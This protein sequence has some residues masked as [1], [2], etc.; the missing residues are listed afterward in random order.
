MEDLSFKVGMDIDKA[1]KSIK[2]LEKELAGTIPAMDKTAKELVSIA[3]GG[4]GMGK[5]LKKVTISSDNYTKALEKMLI[6]TRRL[7]TDLNRTSREVDLLSKTLKGLNVYILGRMFA[8]AL[9]GA[10]DIIE[11]INMFNISM[12][13]YAVEVGNYIERISDLAG[14]D[15]T[16][17]LEASANYTTL[18]RAM[19]MTNKN[20]VILGTS[21]TNLAVDMSSLMNIPISQ[22][23]ADFR[24]GLVGQTEVLT[25]YG[26]DTTEAAIRSEVLAQGI[27]KSYDKM[28][29]GEKMVFRYTLMVKRAGLAHLDFSK[30]IETPANQL[31]ILQQQVVAL[32]RTIGTVFINTLGSVLPY[33]NGFIMAIRV[34]IETIAALLGFEM[35]KFENTAS[36]VAGSFGDISDN[37]DNTTSSVKK[38]KKEIKDAT[39]GF[40]ELH[41]VPQQATNTPSGGGGVGGIGGEIPLPDLTGYTAQLEQVRMKATEIRDRILEWLGFTKEIDPETGKVVWKLKEGY[42]NLEKILD[43]VKA[44]GIA[45]LGW[46]I[47]QLLMVLSPLLSMFMKLL[48]FAKLLGKTLLFNGGVVP[49]LKLVVSALG[50]LSSALGAL[51][52]KLSKLLGINPTLLGILTTLGLMAARSQDLYNNSEVFRE[53]L[54]RIKEIWDKVVKVFKEFGY[55]F[56]NTF[57]PPIGEALSSLGQKMLNLLPESVRTPVKE[58]FTTIGEIVKILDL[59]FKDLLITLGGIGLL[60]TP[61]SPFGIA[62]LTFEAITVAIRGI[63]VMSDETWGNIKTN[64]KE[65][66]T[67][68]GEKFEKVLSDI[69]KG[70]VKVWELVKPVVEPL[71]KILKDVLGVLVEI[72]IYVSGKFKETF[73]NVWEWIKENVVE[74]FKE[75]WEEVKEKFIKV[76]EKITETWEKVKEKF[77]NAWEYLKETFIEPYKE[78][79]EE[80]K[81]KFVK[82]CEVLIEAFGKFAKWLKE[83]WDN[84][85]LPVIKWFGEKMLDLWENF[86]Q[87]SIKGIM[88]LFGEL[89]GEILNVCGGIIDFII[90]V[91]TGDWERAWLGVQNVLRSVWNGLISIVE[92]GINAFINL[93]NWFIKKVNKIKLPDWLGG[94]GFNIDLIGKV[95]LP[96]LDMLQAEIE[97]K[98]SEYQKLDTNKREEYKNQL[99]NSAPSGRSMSYSSVAPSIPQSNLGTSRSVSNVQPQIQ[100]ISQPQETIINNVLTLDGEVIYRNQQQIRSK[101]GVD[102]GNPQFAR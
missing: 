7:G 46:K 49:A 19:G 93:I 77:I 69:G 90:G 17:L 60:F 75:N 79:F 54:G 25:K 38:L 68:I 13:E 61:A 74:K 88:A 76:G 102:F 91:F 2:N 51:W 63:G 80:L 87:P 3:K 10:T 98:N 33:I 96:K 8:N 70:F 78:D 15:M 56:M 4:D 83:Q 62:L 21:L 101:K 48:I 52:I 64:V 34:V 18:A 58:F 55:W 5:S 40:D 97:Q 99:I 53:G 57:I 30:T 28:T 100:Q 59:D 47:G 43:I 27:E 32:S 45:F 82:V 35:P 84:W 92:T 89:F 41:V 42:T 39:L 95:D 26:I 23:F 12:G 1:L 86:I 72:V 6:S 65:A 22:V 29:Q 9:Q 24:S 11:T 36:S 66:L 16:N 37:V 94:F 50:D 31:K 81:E 73:S 85:I 71:W 14:L 67:N 44:I 20:A